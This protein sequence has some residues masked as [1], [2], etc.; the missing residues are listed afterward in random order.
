VGKYY[1]LF[2]NLDKI[3]D[4]DVDEE[5]EKL[6]NKLID[7]RD[8]LHQCKI[9]SK[10]NRDKYVLEYAFERLGGKLGDVINYIDIYGKSR[11]IVFEDTQMMRVN[12]IVMG[13]RFLQSVKIGIIK[14]YVCL[15]TCKWSLK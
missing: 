11:A 2:D 7:V 10:I 9:Q 8:S 12:I 13:T 6:I 4:L 3:L 14:G 15:D 1:S 5:S